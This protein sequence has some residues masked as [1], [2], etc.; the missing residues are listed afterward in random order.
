MTKEYQQAMEPCFWFR[1]SQASQ[2]FFQIEASVKCAKVIAVVI[3][4]LILE[5]KRNK[6]HDKRIPTGN[7][8]MFLVQNFTSFSNLFSDRSKR[9]MRKS[10]CRC[11]KFV[12]LGIKEK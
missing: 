11:N 4:L 3:N 10:Y 8:T 5:S 1:I 12:D 9:Q 2:I 6:F 7:G